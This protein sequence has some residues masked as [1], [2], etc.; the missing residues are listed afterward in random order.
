MGT[1]YDGKR[2]TKEEMPHFY[3][4]IDVLASM[5]KTEGLCNPILEAGAMGVPV[6]STRAGAAPEMIKNGENGFLIERTVDALA[7]A[8]EKMKDPNLRFDMGN[9]FYEE[10]MNNWTW[11]VKIEDFRKMFQKFFE[12]QS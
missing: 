2:L 9:K 5:S 1:R 8:L 10:I 12:M 7:E 6:I 3:N 11:K 4:A